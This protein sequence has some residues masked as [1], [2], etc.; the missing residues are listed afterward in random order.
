L[1][2]KRA[3][4]HGDAR[5]CFRSSVT[6]DWLRPVLLPVALQRSL[7]RSVG[8]TL[9][10]DA[11]WRESSRRFD[12]RQTAALLWPAQ[13]SALVG[14][15]AGVIGVTE[16]DTVVTA[17]TLPLRLRHRLHR[18]WLL[19]EARPQV[20]F[21]RGRSFQP[22]PALTLQRE[23]FFGAGCAACL[24]MRLAIIP[25]PGDMSGPGGA[26]LPRRAIRV[27]FRRPG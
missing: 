10:S 14:L 6:R 8:L 22:V 13:D 5:F 24:A 3:S 16:P 2:T 18:D 9:P 17:W 25:W 19:L 23:A 26:S 15:E 7:S 4:P 21:P 1:P 27:I 11:T 12:L 20:P